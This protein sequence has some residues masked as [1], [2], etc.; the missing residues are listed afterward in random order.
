MSNHTVRTERVTHEA[1][2]DY[3]DDDIV[4]VSPG[5]AREILEAYAFSLTDLDLTQ[6]SRFAVD[7]LVRHHDEET[8]AN[9]GLRFFVDTVSLVSSEHGVW[10]FA[11]SVADS[12]GNR[13]ELLSSKGEVV[14]VSLT[15]TL[16]AHTSTVR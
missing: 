3:R 10:A 1:R 16:H 8:K 11:G 14:L 12:S 9:V 6:G 7:V 13:V 5:T 2:W 4:Q 15:K